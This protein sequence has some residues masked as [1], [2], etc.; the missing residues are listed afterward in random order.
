MSSI[1]DALEK[2]ERERSQGSVPQYQDM[3][4]PEEHSFRW[5]WFWILLAIILCVSLVFAAM[6]WMPSINW[7]NNIQQSSEEVVA[8][9]KNNVLDY[10]QLSELEKS[11]IPE[12]RINVLSLSAE[13]ERSFVMLGEKM[14]REGD[15]VSEDVTLESIKKDHIIFNKKDIL[16]RRE[17]EQ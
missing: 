10:V 3:Q 11:G 12:A 9:E 14:Y 4:P 7:Q 1:L 15:P 16:I 17:L 2:S 13:R 5:K 6:R 8:D